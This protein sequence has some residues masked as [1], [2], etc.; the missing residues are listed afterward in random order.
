MDK[1]LLKKAFREYKKAAGLDYAIT[2][3]D[4][5]GDCMSCVNY[6][7]SK[8]YGEE[9][10]GIWAKHWNTGLNGSGDLSSAKSV[11]I[12]HDITEEQAETLYEV[13][14]KYYN[15]TPSA[16]DPN[17]CFTLYEKDTK[18]YK[19]SYTGTWNGNPR[20]YEDTYAGFERAKDRMD[21]LV[22]LVDKGD[23]EIKD[24][25]INRIF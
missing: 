1:E 11:W 25:T 14:G 17:R 24:I 23:P 3:P 16:Y 21:F 4:N 18:V 22:E 6:A 19:V 13:F 10:K 8:K 20:K 15:M 9:S 12:A 2:R 7:L 5:L